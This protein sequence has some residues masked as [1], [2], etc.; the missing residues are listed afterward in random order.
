M[1]VICWPEEGEEDI[2]SLCGDAHA[3][4]DEIKDHDPVRAS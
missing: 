1:V 2:K 3:T 4:M